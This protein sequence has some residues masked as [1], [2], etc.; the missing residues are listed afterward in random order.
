[1]PD[2][3]DKDIEKAAN[4]I[5][6]RGRE[7]SSVSS[8]IEMLERR[9]NNE[10]DRM[11]REVSAISRQQE[12]ARRKLQNVESSTIPEIEAIGP[13]VSGIMKNIQL[14]VSS[15]STGVKKITIGTA[16][17]IKQ[18]IGD[19]TR[20]LSE[21]LYI[22]KQNFVAMAL[23]KTSPIFGYFVS[24]FV[25][26]D[27]FKRGIENIKAG[28][29]RAFSFIGD[30]IRT[31]FVSIYDRLRAL[32]PFGKKKREAEMGIPHMQHGGYVKRGGM[33][34]VHP[35][36]VIMPI[37]KI[38]AMMEQRMQASTNLS[39]EVNLRL[40]DSLDV[41]GEKMTNL[42][43]SFSAE[44]KRTKAVGSL[45]KE[46]AMGRYERTWEMRMLDSVQ[47][48][49]RSMSEL[50]GF[51]SRWTESVLTKYP[52]F[53]WMSMIGRMAYKIPKMAIGGVV[54]GPF[55]FLFASRGGLQGDIAKAV[56]P[57]N[58]YEQ[59]VNLL[60][61]IYLKFHPLIDDIRMALTGEKSGAPG[62]FR[63]I[64]KFTDWKTISAQSP[65][66]RGI[67]GFKRGMD[68]LEEAPGK[69]STWAKTLGGF[70]G[71]KEEER[72]AIGIQFF[73]KRKIELLETI[74]KG[75]TCVC[76]ST[77][78]S[79][80]ERREERLVATKKAKAEED[81][82]KK[83]AM[84]SQAQRIWGGALGGIR[85]GPKPSL[86]G[87]LGGGLESIFG[88]LAKMMGGGTLT[89]LLLGG[90]TAAGLGA[91]V[92]TFIN[93]GLNYI[94]GEEGLGGWLYDL[95]HGPKT[96][97][98]R[99]KDTLESV[100]EKIASIIVWP[101]KKMFD[102][103]KAGLRSIWKKVS[104]IPG[105]GW[106][107][108]KAGLAYKPSD[109]EKEIESFSMA[110]EGAHGPPKAPAWSPETAALHKKLEDIDKRIAAAKESRAPKE[111]R[112]REVAS[113]EALKA[114]QTRKF[115]AS[116]T[117][118]AAPKPS[119]MKPMAMHEALRVVKGD[120]FTGKT[121]E[122]VNQDFA[123][124][125]VAAV[126]EYREQTGENLKIKVNEAY[127]SVEDQKKL[128]DK[129]LRETGGDIT[130]TR[131]WVAPPGSSF[132]NF[133][134]ALDID[135]GQLNKLDERGLLQKYGLN[136]PMGHEPWHLEVAFESLE[137]RRN[138]LSKLKDLSNVGYSRDV[139]GD[140]EA[141]EQAKAKELSVYGSRTSETIKTEA[142]GAI[143]Q[144]KTTGGEAGKA[145]AE[146]SKTTIASVNPAT[147]T[148]VNDGRQTNN[149]VINNTNVPSGSTNPDVQATLMG[150]NWG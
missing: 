48:M 62:S 134:Y 140:R 108:E 118:G 106:I 148:T 68:W 116:I 89:K 58:Y 103:V 40:M 69:V 71:A 135:R 83:A 27:I 23:A 46:F 91:L 70:R 149:V 44:R 22:H 12:M 97:W 85:R 119:G 35:A 4:A 104:S 145:A 139:T 117:A 7:I 51:W 28:F 29:S 150:W 42:S 114:A 121:L 120:Y 33:A 53:R 98:E 24:K 63:R 17:T 102:L 30:K 5:T 112:E 64:K 45:F 47:Q 141:Y 80:K 146:G 124:R 6:G 144:A 138:F 147:L 115:H 113:L 15:L 34:M 123:T 54:L 87:K 110:K 129:K 57:K 31:L 126:Q 90:L 1:M 52:A 131:K 86:M 14:A 13:R 81:A 9:M 122:G 128:W 101:F 39:Q 3:T 21:D 59:I 56:R 136:R 37:E 78:K 20:A 41:L 55:K 143:A 95:F 93:K 73:E 130:K 109:I 43:D 38:F 84:V 96:I 60:S 75:T 127:R 107:M 36:E 111:M 105:V 65:V 137:Q 77:M 2:M 76:E 125:L 132:H 18:A 19:Y 10:Q 99:I 100:T 25:Q 66:L 72:K 49:A 8:R 11:S 32:W 94:F 61:L 92:G 50:P 26:T 16:A 79:A 67:R 133:G 88:G 74:A 142:A 82:R